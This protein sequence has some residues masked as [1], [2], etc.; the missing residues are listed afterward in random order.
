MTSIKI[1]LS[2]ITT[3]Q[4]AV[5]IVLKEK[6]KLEKIVSAFN[7]TDASPNFKYMINYMVGPVGNSVL[8]SRDEIYVECDSLATRLAAAGVVELNAEGAYAEITQATFGTM[9]E[10][11]MRDDKLVIN[12]SEIRYKTKTKKQWGTLPENV[13]IVVT[14][15]E[16]TQADWA[17]FRQ[18][19]LKEAMDAV[20]NLGYTVDES[21]TL[22]VV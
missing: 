17:E 14:K 4:D 19:Q 21:G 22:V 20:A 12:G 10:D 5:N 13:Q 11:K 8:I 1:D 2:T 3:A 18:R 16:L 9:I 7:H 15:L 6:M